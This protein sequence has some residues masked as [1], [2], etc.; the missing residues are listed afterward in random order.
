MFYTLISL[1]EVRLQMT[2]TSPFSKLGG[3]SEDGDFGPGNPM[4]HPGSPAPNTAHRVT[5]RPLV[6]SVN[7][8]AEVIYGH[9][10]PAQRLDVT[11]GASDT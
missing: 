1:E 6:T 11:L 2:T 9:P 8:I 4:A 7:L 3:L 10:T 5:P